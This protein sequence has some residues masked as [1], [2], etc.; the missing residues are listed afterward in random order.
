[1]TVL[2]GFPCD[3]ISSRATTMTFFEQIKTLSFLPD[4][5][6]L[7]GN[8]QL[9]DAI[10]SYF[11]LLPPGVR[12][13]IVDNYAR[14]AG[15]KNRR[16]PSRMTIF[17]TNLCNMK[18]AHC[19][20]VKEH[21][22][23]L[24]EMG[25]EDFH[26]LFLSVQGKVSQIL[27]TGGEPTLRKD[28]ADIIVAASQVGKIPTVNLFSN[29]LRESFI[30][31]VLDKVIG[32][33]D[34]RL[35]FQ[36]SIDGLEPFH[37]KNRRIPGAMG[38]AQTTIRRILEL[39]KKFPKRF[40]R[41]I[42]TTAITRSNLLDLEPIV[43][44]VVGSGALPAFTFVR[45]ADNGVFNLSDRTLLSDFS[46]EEKRTD[47]SPKFT[48]ESFLTVEDMDRAL[49]I[50]NRKLWSRHRS[51]LVFAY[52]RVTL[53]AI[54]NAVASKTS[55]LTQECR[56]GFDDLV[57]LPDG[58]IARCEMLKAAA[59]LKDFDFDLAA[60]LRSP[61][62]R[63]YLKATSGCW[64]THDCGVGVSIMKEPQLIKKLVDS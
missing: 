50:L 36:T 23:Q 8:F 25:I 21:Q 1:M 43:D 5:R 18:C 32:A 55:P 52:N 47:G 19:F 59:N 33:C 37:D 13:M 56:M 15:R 20:I 45:S 53:T 6:F 35:N 9:A 31:D 22:H 63:S 41:V 64:C 51:E 29:G 17:L 44:L 60:L 4:E 48:H 49:G 57:I 58:Q 40:G 27:L 14:M 34:V 26:K 38:K 7:L 12:N 39:K 11:S 62:W 30:V 28:L 24:N 61:A 16:F 10:F 3:P 54:R 42:A 46:P 2:A